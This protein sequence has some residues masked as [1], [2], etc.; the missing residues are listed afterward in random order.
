[1]CTFIRVFLLDPVPEDVNYPT[2]KIGRT[3]KFSHC[4]WFGLLAV[5]RPTLVS[6]IHCSHLTHSCKEH[7]LSVVTIV[8]STQLGCNLILSDTL[9][10]CASSSMKITPHWN[11]V[12]AVHAKVLCVDFETHEKYISVK[13][14]RRKEGQLTCDFHGGRKTEFEAAGGSVLQMPFG[15]KCQFL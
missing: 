4:R 5:N 15:E 14:R 8:R 11:F 10:P 1:M 3:E 6:L 2:F 7:N 13:E 9:L 12:C